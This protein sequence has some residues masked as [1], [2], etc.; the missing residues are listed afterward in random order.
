MADLHSMTR[1]NLYQHYRAYYVPNNA[2]LSL[3]GD[4]DPEQMFARIRTLFEPIPAAPV[5]V[6]VAQPEPPLGGEQ[7]LVVEG[8]GE[9]TYVQVA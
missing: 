6:R 4:F 9:T 1:E 2:V 5:P 3:A 8:P 7:R